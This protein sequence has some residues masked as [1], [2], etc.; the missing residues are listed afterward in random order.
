[1]SNIKQLGPLSYL[2][3][4]WSGFGV[5]R[6]S[7]GEESSYSHELIFEPI[8]Q[9]RFSSENQVLNVLRF[10][11]K[12]WGSEDDSEFNNLIPVYEENGYLSW[13]ANDNDPTIGTIVK[14]VSNPRGLSFM[15]VS[16]VVSIAETSVQM[17]CDREQ[18]PYGGI[19]QSPQLSEVYPPVVGYISKWQVD[20]NQLIVEDTTLLETD[21]GEPFYQTDNSK[22]VR[23]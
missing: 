22:L 23:Y 9:L 4:T 8:P 18:L 10:S 19:M 6:A 3:G 14:Q 12:M 13:V 17:K 1:M 20:G 2:V 7:S 5:D 11:S 16:D 15:A 21:T